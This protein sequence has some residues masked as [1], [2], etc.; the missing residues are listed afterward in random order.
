MKYF[1]TD[2]N[3]TE[4]ATL[5][6]A[7]A[8]CHAVKHNVMDVIHIGE[9]YGIETDVDDPRLYFPVEA[10]I[11]PVEYVHVEGTY[12]RNWANILIRDVKRWGGRV[13]Y[14]AEAFEN[15]YLDVDV[16]KE[17]DGGLVLYMLESMAL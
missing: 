10:G 6:D 8:I 3:N 4:P 15:I 5:T 2:T 17:S 12:P 9:G 13:N 7:R 14:A 16:I 1:L 11:I